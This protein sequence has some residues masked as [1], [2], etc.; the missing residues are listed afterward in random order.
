MDL[1][2]CKCKVDNPTKY[3]LWSFDDD[4]INICDEV[5]GKIFQLSDDS[6]P[7]RKTSQ[8]S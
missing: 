5:G 1:C 4:N 8:A 2:A 3:P 6:D 7:T